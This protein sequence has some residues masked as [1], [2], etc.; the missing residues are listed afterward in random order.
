MAKR[1]IDTTTPYTVHGVLAGAYKGKDI[2][3]RALL[4]HA[5]QDD[6]ATAVCKTV[7]QYSLCDMV[8]DDAVTCP[9][10]LE[11]IARRGLVRKPVEE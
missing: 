8:E 10:C 3:E 5:S 9:T 4:N 1:N 7:R 11:R 2:S 6:S